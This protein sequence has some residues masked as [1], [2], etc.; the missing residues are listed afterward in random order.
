MPK[1]GMTAITFRTEIAELLRTKAKQ[2][3][4]GINTYLE[5]TL[6]GP[7]Q[8]CFEDRPRTV[9]HMENPRELISSEISLKQAAAN[10][11]SAETVGF[12]KWT[13]R[14]LNPR[15]PHCECGVRTRLNYRPYVLSGRNV[16]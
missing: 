3:N 5:A 13:G 10:E 6:I 9:P 2:A 7:S 16:D 11:G 12:C 1:K 8:A 14:D 4:M 15:L